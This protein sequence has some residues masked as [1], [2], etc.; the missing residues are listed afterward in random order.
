MLILE[1]FGAS[2]AEVSRKR[3]LLAYGLLLALVALTVQAYILSEFFSGRSLIFKKSYIPYRAGW[4]VR[5]SAFREH[6]Y[7]YNRQVEAEKSIIGGNIQ[8]PISFCNHLP[9]NFVL[10]API[11]ILPLG[12]S[13]LVFTACSLSIVFFGFASFWSS[14]SQN[15]WSAALLLT[16]ALVASVPGAMA[17]YYAAYTVVIVGLLAFF[18]FATDTKRPLLAGLILTLLFLKPNYFVYAAALLAGEKR[19]K[20]LIFSALLLTAWM[21]LSGFIVGWQNLIDYPRIAAISD[22][23]YPL[24]SPDK[25]ICCRAFLTRLMPDLYALKI[26][27]SLFCGVAVLFG[28][29]FRKRIF[30]RNLLIGT[31]ILAALFFSPH[32]HLYEETVLIVCMALSAVDLIKKS[33]P[34]VKR[35]YDLLIISFPVISWALVSLNSGSISISLLALN[36]VYLLIAVCALFEDRRKPTLS[37]YS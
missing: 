32:S 9:T 13:Y 19:Y 30:D 25:M 21:T 3:A 33:D 37:E 15:S 12:S 23:N 27:S 10:F 4:M 7:D 24:V 17:V 26:S 31:A 6:I 20:S 22:V 29:L 2:S 18:I 35:T 14:R 28:W 1:L 11:A 34:P 8:L 16:A 36:G 5:N